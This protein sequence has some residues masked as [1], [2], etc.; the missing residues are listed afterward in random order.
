MLF[1]FALGYGARLLVP[2]F[3]RPSSWRWLEVG[4][5]VVMWVVAL[6]LALG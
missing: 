3:A 4:V 6:R 1:F 5:G 2:V